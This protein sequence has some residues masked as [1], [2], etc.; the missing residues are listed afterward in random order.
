MFSFKQSQRLKRYIGFKTVKGKEASNRFEKDLFKFRNNSFYGKT[1]E[2]LIK[3]VDVRLVANAKDY[4][5]LINRP[6]FISWKI[7]NKKYVSCS[8]H[9]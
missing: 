2:N 5:K 1:M 3:R 4:Q 7:F 9:Q 8:P 6:R